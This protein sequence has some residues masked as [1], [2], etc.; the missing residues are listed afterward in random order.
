VTE[1]ASALPPHNLSAVHEAIADRV[2]ER[3]CIVVRDR[4]LTYADVTDRSRRLA[5][6]LHERGLGARPAGRVGL[7]NHE[8]SADRLAVYAHSYK[9][10]KAWVFVETI[11]RSPGG[12]ADYRW[13][14]ARATDAR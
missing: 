1:Q 6:L 10:P 13:A 12:K 5:R 2:P 4:R 9:L 11:Q 3:E 8:A 7:A 14:A